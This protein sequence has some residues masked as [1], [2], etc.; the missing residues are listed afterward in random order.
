MHM[1]LKKIIYRIYLNCIY[2]KYFWESIP[3]EDF[4]VPFI[5]KEEMEWG[6][7]FFV[8]VKYRVLIGLNILGRVSK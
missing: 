3:R 4:L 6:L 8:C 2:F 5:V 1:F 7:L